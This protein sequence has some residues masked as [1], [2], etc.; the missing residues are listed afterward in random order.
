MSYIDTCCLMTFIW[1]RDELRIRKRLGSRKAE[2]IVPR[3]H[4]EF[5]TPMPAV[6]EAMCKIMEKNCT[7]ESMKAF[8]ELDRLL[9]NGFLTTTYLRPDEQT[10][11]LASRLM[12]IG[13]PDDRETIS[14]M[15]AF[16]TASSAV[17][18]ECSTMYTEDQNLLYNGNL[19]KEIDEWRSQ[20]GYPIMSV[21][22]L[23]KSVR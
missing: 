1:H 11:R 10:F 17:D 12:T 22:S 19:K 9:R 16:T 13:N 15:D 6:G 8:S 2:S 18:P 5:R 3:N 14:A 23:L 20:Y 7:A 21:R 4:P